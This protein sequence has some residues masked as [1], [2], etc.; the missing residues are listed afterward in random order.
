M[1][2]LLARIKASSIDPVL[3]GTC[4]IFLTVLIVE[5]TTVNIFLAISV[6]SMILYVRSRTNAPV[7]G[8]GVGSM[9]LGLVAVVLVQL[10]IRV[11]GLSGPVSA[12]GLHTIQ[13]SFL[14]VLLLSVL[15][16]AATRWTQLR[17][18]PTS[19]KLRRAVR[20]GLGA[21]SL[22]GILIVVWQKGTSNGV[23]DSRVW[24][25]LLVVVMVVL[26]RRFYQIYYCK[27]LLHL[28]QEK[29]HFVDR[30]VT[31]Q[32]KRKN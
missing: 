32:Q 7:G 23:V 10:L 20:L 6:M 15:L 1:A 13:R 19:R 26:Q 9:A 24:Y 14:M 18:L 17:K 22:V 21:P 25:V 12:S 2:Y 11:D 31:K 3:A 29:A 8:D 30:H 16:V 4:F 27:A 28:R 5:N